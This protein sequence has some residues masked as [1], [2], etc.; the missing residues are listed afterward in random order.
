VLESLWQRLFESIGKGARVLDVGTGGGDVAILMARHSL[1]GD[2][3]WDVTGV[4]AAEIHPPEGLPPTVRDQL[5]F[6][7][8]T[9]AEKLP[10]DDDSFDLITSQFAVE[11]ADLNSA[12]SECLRILKPGAGLALLAHCEGSGL[13]RGSRTT[14]GV[15]DQALEEG[16]LF[17]CADQ[18]A[19]RVQPLLSHKGVQALKEDAVA[20]RLRAT[21]N[22]S[23]GRLQ[24]SVTSRA[25]APLVDQL[26]ADT[27]SVIRS[28]NHFSM[29]KVN[30]ELARIRGKYVDSRQRALDQLEAASAGE[31]IPAVLQALG[32]TEDRISSEIVYFKTDPI[33]RY[34]HVT[35]Q[36][37]I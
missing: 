6:L 19:Q 34:F 8:E 4:D 3:D 10:F 37:A 12:L 28:C 22:E 36:P 11:Y 30:E 13:V 25:I 29:L 31:R 32:I 1:A 14:V 27:T 16:G 24:Q 17:D 2:L 18:L 5:T 33:G 21:F 23:I 7:Q 15:L 26:L 20:N 35:R 9:R